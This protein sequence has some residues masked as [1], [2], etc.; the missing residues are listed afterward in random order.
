MAWEGRRSFLRGISHGD[1]ECAKEAG[2]TVVEVVVDIVA[3]D[4]GCH[5]DDRRVSIE[6]SYQGCGGAAVEVG[7]HNVHEDEIV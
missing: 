1:L 3:A 7:H 4:V 5:R 2:R 6:L